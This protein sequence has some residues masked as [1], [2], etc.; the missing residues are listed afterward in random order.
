MTAAKLSNPVSEALEQYIAAACARVA[1]TWPLDQFI[2]VNPYWG[3]VGQP[4]EVAASTLGALAGTRLTMPRSWFQ[5]EWAA[6]RLTHRHLK[7]AA[8]C[9]VSAQGS[10]SADDGES[11]VK[12]SVQ[13]AALVND[14][15]QALERAEPNPTNPARLPLITDLRDAAGAPRPGPSWNALVTHQVSQHCAAYF[16]DQGSAWGLERSRGLY[17]SWREQLAHDHG[18]PWQQGPKALH[19]RLAQLPAEPR[20]SIATSLAALGIAPQGQ[21][22]Y[23]SA[24]LLSMGGWAAWCAYQR[25]QARLAGGDDEQIEHLLAIRLAWEWLLHGDAELEAGSA[26]WAAAWAQAD[27]AAEALAAAQRTDWLLQHALEMAQQQETIAGLTRPAPV[28]AFGGAS[29]PQFQAVFCIDV[30]SEVFRRALEAA[31]PGAQ[32]LGFAG[33][34]GLPMAY[35]PLGSAL[36]RPQLPGLL[37]PTLQVTESVK[38]SGL[39]AST[40]MAQGPHLAQV[41]AAKR[42][43]ALNWR[44]RWAAFRAAPSSAFSFVESLGLLYGGKLLSSSLASE[45]PA[46]RWEDTGLSA[47]AAQQ[48]RP[49]LPDAEDGVQAAGALA[50]GILSTMGLVRNFAPLVLIAG[51][52]SQSANNAHASGLDCGACGGQSGEVNARVL[53]DLLNRPA[54]RAELAVRGIAIPAGTHFVPG[55]HNT[56][57]D[58]L[59]LFDTQDVPAPLAGLLATL[60]SALGRAGVSA[61][62]ERAES[63]GLGEL[64]TRPAALHQAVRERAND[65]SQVRPEWGLANNASFI[66]APRARSRNMNLAGRSFLHDYDHALDPENKVLTLI[67]TAPMVVTNWINLQYHAS[68]VDNRRY[69]SGNKLLHN[70]VGGHIGVFEGNGG[71][72]RIGLPLQSL[73]DGERLRHTPLRLSVYIEAPCA[74]IE[75]VLSEHAT[76]RDLVDNGWLHLFCIDAFT[77]RVVQRWRGCWRESKAPVAE[78]HGRPPIPAASETAP[79]PA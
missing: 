27:A 65:W 38:A 17:G 75:S 48:L 69:G 14:L 2:A 45:A 9:A 33:F 32:T 39:A 40:G 47:G 79:V 60:K 61:R 7:Q 62:A 35:Q 72:L 23:L 25:W 28:G 66:V 24:V 68:T 10:E 41:L 4:I 71:D 37:S 50:H 44:E 51:H 54:L 26:P 63:L 6:G 11:D 16:D 29:T 13:V 22:A 20:A 1:P 58:D 53:A 67:M 18:L 19:A 42:K 43:N 57:T 59:V 70:V 77:G 74:A 46:T 3:W 21:Q 55:V 73:H 78:P 76:V 56:T 8:D 64:V 5:A 15:V 34:F 49:S 12:R 36:S 30:R 31:A 52:G